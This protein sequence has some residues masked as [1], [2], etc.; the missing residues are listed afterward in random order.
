MEVESLYEKSA[1]L[2]NAQRN[3]F[4]RF[5]YDEIL[6]DSRM[7]CI[8]GARGVGKS[9]LMWQR[10]K[11]ERYSR[12]EAIYVTLDDLWFTENRLTDLVEYH[13]QH[14]GKFIFIDEVHRYPYPNWSQEL[15]TIYDGFPNL[16]I[17]F[18]GSSLLQID[19]S[20]ADLSRR[21]LFYTMPGLSLREYI[22]ITDNIEL[23]PIPLEDILVHHEDIATEMLSQ[24]K[25]TPLFEDY[26]RH[27]YYPF[28]TEGIKA[29]PYALQQIINTI[30]E[31]DLPSSEKVEYATIVK[32][33]RLFRILATTAPF[34]LNATK[35][36]ETIEAARQSVVKMFGTLET[37]ALLTLLYSGKN[38][39]KQLVKPEKVY[40]D[41][42]NIL[43]A[44]N[45]NVNI[46]TERETFFANQLK[47]AHVLSYTPNGD[48]LVDEQ[49]TFE[50][51]GS[52]KSFKQIKDI[53]DSYLVIG[54]SEYG[55]HN[56]I[57][58]W[59]FGMLY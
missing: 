18:S 48:F 40:L 20:Q 7:I 43:H 15:K 31:I 39:F 51:G 27:G 38:S 29:Y 35:L 36:G 14:G 21:C 23:N 19:M 2:V 52:Y 9:T 41:N 12:T 47:Q 13:Y 54:D 55:H 33:K 4:T 58:L 1:R 34:T 53:P 50:V 22:A 57:P 37:A 16:H 59:M 10:M 8:K 32:L 46:G 17:V 42:T 44:L 49:Y 45:T 56:R 25:I 5:L 6:W 30:L 24:V 3:I 11:K 28:F 26:L